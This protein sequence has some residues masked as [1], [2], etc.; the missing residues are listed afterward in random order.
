MASGLTT[1][2]V[3]TNCCQ[4]E[5]PIV[6]VEEMYQWIDLALQMQFGDYKTYNLI[7]KLCKSCSRPKWKMWNIR[8]FR[9]FR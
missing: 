6:Q 4:R 1:T 5:Y 8:I 3:I 9:Y 2:V 7:S